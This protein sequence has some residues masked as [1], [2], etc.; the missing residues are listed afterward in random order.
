MLAL[1]VVGDAAIVVGEDIFWIEPDRL[2][3]VGNRTIITA[4]GV[5]GPPRLM[6]AKAF[7]GSSRIASSRSAIARSKSPFSLYALPRLTNA[8]TLLGL[9]LINRLQA[10]IAT[11]SVRLPHESASS[12]ADAPKLPTLIRA[13]K[14][15][16]AGKR[17]CTSPKVQRRASGYGLAPAQAANKNIYYPNLERG[18][19]FRDRPLA[20][21]SSRSGR[22]GSF[23]RYYGPDVVLDGS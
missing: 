22:Y 4:L 12:T 14:R 17:N 18:R 3:E 6:C 9:P 23:R 7:F 19:N 21:V 16:I 2:V 13:T 1:A 8:K 10:A 5:V 20:A 15:T 11:S